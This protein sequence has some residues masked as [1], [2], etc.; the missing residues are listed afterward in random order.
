VFLGGQEGPRRS[1]QIV[2]R[3]RSSQRAEIAWR[4]TRA[5][6]QGGKADEEGRAP[7]LL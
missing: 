2:V 5:E 6:R 1:E 4:F 3:V 7:L